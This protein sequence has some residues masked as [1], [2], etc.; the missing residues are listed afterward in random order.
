MRIKT[1]ESVSCLIID[2]VVDGLDVESSAVAVTFSC[3]PGIAVFS[4]SFLDN[5]FTFSIRANHITD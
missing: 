3:L 2:T 4:K 1:K 5:L